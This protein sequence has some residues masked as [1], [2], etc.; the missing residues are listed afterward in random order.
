[1]KNFIFTLTILISALGLTN[2]QN[3]NDLIVTEIVFG[4]VGNN[5]TGEVTN[6]NHSVEVFNPTDSP[7]DL[8]NYMIELLPE[9]GEKT[10]VELVG[11]VPAEDVFVISNVTANSGIAGVS[12]VLDLLLSFEGKVAIQL[13]K[14]TGEVI[15]KIGR[16]GISSTATTI[17]FSALLN[18]PSYLESLDINLGS[19]ENLLIRRSRLVQ[20]GKNEFTNEDLFKE[21][22]IYPN[23]EI[24]DLGDHKNA[25]L[26]PVLAWE[27]VTFM[28][29]EASRDEN[30][31]LPVFGTITLTSAQPVSGSV[32]VYVTN[33][34]HEFV[35]F[36]PGAVV[37][38]DFIT[39]IDPFNNQPPLNST[40]DAIEIELLTV[41]N[42][43][44]IESPIEGT[45]FFFE[46]DDD[47]NNTAG[48]I[49][50]N[51]ADVFDIEII[52]DETT[53]TQRLYLNSLLNVTPTIVDN[54][55]QISASNNIDIKEVLVFSMEGKS[56]E[57]F[58]SLSGDNITLDLS[59]LA[60]R[61]YQI[62]SIQTS[63]GVITKKIFKK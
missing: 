50:D 25:C 53:A 46:I 27:N 47:G 49:K 43:F 37:G 36:A 11:I 45:G 1:M 54:T 3:C 58:T 5:L 63:V 20:K 40:T 2:A 32:E 60:S 7:I 23:F 18:D 41:I 12:D 62:L 8:S 52:D 61:G 42:D 44:F 56:T 17:D 16:Q 9:T 22:A 48:A 21:W 51:N 10:I 26:M 6:F 39:P 31:S 24:G 34:G 19:L 13:T 38:E 14:T 55:I 35:P 59:S 15:D 4:N 28:N 33:F 57:R 30:N 29:P